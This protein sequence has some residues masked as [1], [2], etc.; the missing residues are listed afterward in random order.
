MLNI[1]SHLGNATSN[2]NETPQ[3]SYRVVGTNT[4]TATLEKGLA[5]YYKS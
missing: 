3:L 5:V 2:H 1:I 4:H